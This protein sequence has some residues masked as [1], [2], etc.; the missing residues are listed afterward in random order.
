[1]KKHIAKKYIHS[2]TLYYGGED[3]LDIYT[4]GRMDEYAHTYIIDM[5]KCIQV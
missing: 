2:I 5:R 4:D 1:M 3:T